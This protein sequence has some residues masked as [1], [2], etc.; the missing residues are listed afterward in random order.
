MYRFYTPLRLCVLAVLFLLLSSLCPDTVARAADT[1]LCPDGP[2]SARTAGETAAVTRQE[3]AGLAPASLAVPANEPADTP[4]DAPAPV[5]PKD[6]DTIVRDSLRAPVV[7]YE[8]LGIPRDP[9]LW[10]HD[11]IRRGSVREVHA[12]LTAGAQLTEEVLFLAA[13]YTDAATLD[14]LLQRAGYRPTARFSLGMKALEHQSDSQAGL[15]IRRRIVSLLACGSH[16]SSL[17]DVTLLHLAALTGNTDVARF[18]FAQGLSPNAVM[19]N[20]ATPMNVALSAWLRAWNPM[21]MAVNVF[22]TISR[23][24]NY[25]GFIYDLLDRGGEPVPDELMEQHRDTMERYLVNLACDFHVPTK[26]QGFI[27]LSELL[28]QSCTNTAWGLIEFQFFNQNSRYYCQLVLV[29]LGR[30]K[31]G[32]TSLAIPFVFLD[33]RFVLP[34]D[35]ST[36]LQ[37]TIWNNG[38]T[39]TREESLRFMEKLGLDLSD[40]SFWQKM[41]ARF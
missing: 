6:T 12:A 8:D 14:F 3:P 31:E 28:E 19:S 9:T 13:I 2:G 41:E 25:P 38:T 24:T 15:A 11:S 21:R 22:R 32:N 4:V 27:S 33:D 29:F 36:G 23:D 16:T 17:Q 20:G 39:L 40:S 10:L 5:F 26:H 37:F 30:L 34:G 1:G 7:P 18:L 35:R